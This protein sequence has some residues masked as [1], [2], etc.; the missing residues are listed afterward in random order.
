MVHVQHAWTALVVVTVAA[1]LPAL[2]C[3]APVE[4]VEEP[5]APGAYTI[6]FPSVAAAVAT[7]SV[8]VVVVD[9][10]ADTCS[11]LVAKERSRQAL[12][13]VVATSGAVAPC[14]FLAASDDAAS[15]VLPFGRRAF[16][17]VATRAGEPFLI[18]CSVG[19][20]EKDAPPVRIDLTLFSNLVSVP[21]TTC[22]TLAA[23]CAGSC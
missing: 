7:E 6:E 22:A 18:G 12:S 11:T 1:A 2:A 5:P 14:S 16:L 15:L 20:I 17:A 21:T 3:A 4:H 10:G 19:D 13:G 9:A 8:R 23:R